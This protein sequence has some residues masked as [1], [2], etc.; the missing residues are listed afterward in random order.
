M[1]M[2]S[3][4]AFVEQ[5]NKL[6]KRITFCEKDVCQLLCAHLNTQ[7]D[8]VKKSQLPSQGVSFPV[9]GHTHLLIYSDA[10]TDQ[11]QLACSIAIAVCAVF[12][13]QQEV[14]D[15]TAV[16]NVISTL[17]YSELGVATCVFQEL[18]AQGLVE[19]IINAGKIATTLGVARSV[20]TATLKKLEGAGLIESRSLGMKGTFIRVKNELLFVEIK[21]F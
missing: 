7:V 8:L 16:R 4:P 2:L 3:L 9:W 18:Y 13:R 15:K 21:K 19:D 11:E 20:I 14:A 5:L 17:S 12:I 1:H 10:L 6:I